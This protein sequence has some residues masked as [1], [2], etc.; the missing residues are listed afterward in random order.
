MEDREKYLTGF[1]GGMAATF[2]FLML[3]AVACSST[4]ES[5]DTI[6]EHGCGEYNSTNG[7]FVW[8]K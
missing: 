2:C 7:K 8:K 5:H 6:I 1:F 4:N 3:L